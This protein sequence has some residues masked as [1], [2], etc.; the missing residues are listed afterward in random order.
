MKSPPWLSDRAVA[1][2][3]RVASA[4]HEPGRRYELLE[5]IGRGG[6]GVV[7]RAVDL[8]L[9]RD[10]ALKILQADAGTDLETRLL[11]EARIIGRLEHPG[12]VPIH[13]VG[14]L[15]DGR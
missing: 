11:R 14:R 10:V 1:H 8:E 6:M 4:R 13:D 5:E 3:S 9:Q 15:E 12:L 2:L 7:H